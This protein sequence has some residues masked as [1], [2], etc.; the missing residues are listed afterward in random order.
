MSLGH[1]R[2]DTPQPNPE[3]NTT[4]T[5]SFSTTSP[6]ALSAVPGSRVSRQNPRVVDERVDELVKR[7]LLFWR[8]GR[9]PAL[10][11]HRDQVLGVFQLDLELVQ[12]FRLQPTSPVKS[13][14]N[15]KDEHRGVPWNLDRRSP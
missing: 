1:E 14:H 8:Q 9:V 7:V 2:N 11:R 6:V 5:Q 12:Y 15:I 13:L 4:S 10:G 3:S